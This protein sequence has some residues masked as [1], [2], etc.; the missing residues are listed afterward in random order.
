MERPS[1]K[2]YIRP[3]IKE[4]LD[5]AHV[6]PTREH[7]EGFVSQFGLMG[8]FVVYERSCRNPFAQVMP[9]LGKKVCFGGDTLEGFNEKFPGL[10]WDEKIVWSGKEE[11][12]DFWRQ[13]WGYMRS[14]ETAYAAIMTH[15]SERKPFQFGIDT[16]QGFYTGEALLTPQ[17]K[18]T[19]TVFVLDDDDPETAELR[20]AA[21]R[22]VAYKLNQS[23]PMQGYDVV[24]GN[25][26]YWKTETLLSYIWSQFLHLLT[27][28]KEAKRCLTC[29][30][31][32]EKVKKPEKNGKRTKAKEGE[33]YER[34]SWVRHVTCGNREYQRDHR[35]EL[36]GKILH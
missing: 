30:R 15:P 21:A 13:E 14:F 8:C 4:I 5:F 20:R 6:E 36:K 17:E 32:E 28:T 2:K 23:V 25:L 18:E 31:W 22:V 29:G 10:R 9:P 11:D 34:S 35:R 33:G 26:V 16:P 12:L 27:G 3:R 19:E 1:P 7:L 24:N